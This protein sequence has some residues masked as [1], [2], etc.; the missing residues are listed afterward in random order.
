MLPGHLQGLTPGDNDWGSR[1]V[2]VD[3]NPVVGICRHLPASETLTDREMKL[4]DQGLNAWVVD[5]VHNAL[6]I[7]IYQIGVAQIRA[8]G[9]SNCRGS[10]PSLG[11]PGSST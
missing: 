5:S 6:R 8:R 3:D 7:W 2:T 4:N 1:G 10:E 11:L 9:R